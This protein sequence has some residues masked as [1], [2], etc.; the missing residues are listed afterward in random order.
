MVSLYALF[1]IFVT[2]FAIIGAVRGW[3]K[4]VLVTFSSI[5]AIFIIVL[6]TTYIPFMKPDSGMSASTRFYIQ[7]FVVS[8]MVIFG[9]LTPKVRGVLGDR[10]ARQ[11]FADILLGL[12]IGALNGYLI[13]G[14]IWY[15]MDASNYP[16][17]FITGPNPDTDVGQAAI[18]LLNNMPPNYLVPPWIYFAVALAFIFVVVVF[19]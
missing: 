11:R 7:L 5:L 19:I 4:E 1:W 9:Y 8:I 12:V 10:L 2:I 17:S 13:I 6:L 14:T 16:I 3:A 15:Y 18:S